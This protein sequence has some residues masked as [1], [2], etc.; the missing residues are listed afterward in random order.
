MRGESYYEPFFYSSI[1]VTFFIALFAL[2][3]IAALLHSKMDRLSPKVIYFYAVSLVGL[4]F[5]CDGV[6]VLITMAADLLASLGTLNNDIKK[7]FVSCV[8]VLI[9]AVPLYFFHW[10]QVRRGLGVDE[11]V[12]LAWPYYKFTVL[13]LSAVGTAC[14]LIVIFY[15]SLNGALGLSKFNLDAFNKVLGS[16]LVGMAVWLYHWFTKVG[17]D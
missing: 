10:L 9:V 2:L 15:Q 13:G 14:F 1:L 11:E 5:L 6:S 7:A 12:K 8:S 3:I 16:G 4:L 17:A